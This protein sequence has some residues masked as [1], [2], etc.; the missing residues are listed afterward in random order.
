MV[1]PLNFTSSIKLLSVVAS[2]SIDFSDNE[3]C[4]RCA[5]FAAKFEE[6]VALSRSVDWS[7]GVTR[8][9]ETLNPPRKALVGLYLS[10]TNTSSE[11]STK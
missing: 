5:P 6:P 9:S 1:P 2:K 11:H 3:N 8:V 7:S 4:K 10:I